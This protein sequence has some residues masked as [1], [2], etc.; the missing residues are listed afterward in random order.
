MED[1]L[2]KVIGQPAGDFET[3]PNLSIYFQ[4]S[5]GRKFGQC[6]RYHGQDDERCPLLRDENEVGEGTGRLG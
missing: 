3:G 5:A 1:G 4:R 6:D 2:F